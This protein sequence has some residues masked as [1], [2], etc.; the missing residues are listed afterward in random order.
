MSEVGYIILTLVVEEE[1]GDGLFAAHCSELGTATCGT[2][3]DEAFANLEEAVEV[4]LN[5]LEEVETRERVFQEMGITIHSLLP[6]NYESSVPVK[7]D[8]I[9]SSICRRI[10]ASATV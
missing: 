6:A 9:V 3:I 7:V 8:Q 1:E 4:H 2:T 5:A 10:P